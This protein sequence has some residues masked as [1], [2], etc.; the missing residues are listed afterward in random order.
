MSKHETPLTRAYWQTIGG[1]LIEEFL[2]VRGSKK[3]GKRLLDGIILPN[4]EKRIMHW[5]DV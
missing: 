4:E 5:R 3:N 2:I 1:T